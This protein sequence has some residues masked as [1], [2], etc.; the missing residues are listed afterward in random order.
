MKLV[1]PNLYLGWQDALQIIGVQ[2]IAAV[3]F[4]VML[5]IYAHWSDV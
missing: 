2:L 3:L 1:D 5:K 4:V